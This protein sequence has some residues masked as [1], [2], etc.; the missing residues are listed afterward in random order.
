MPRGEEWESLNYRLV[1]VK[2][3]SGVMS[4]GVLTE[5]GLLPS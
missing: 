5:K 2:E 1:D 4:V 3:S